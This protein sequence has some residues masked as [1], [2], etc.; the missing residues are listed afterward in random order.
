[1]EFVAKT[2]G[3]IC[4]W[5]LAYQSGSILRR[6]FSDWAKEIFEMKTHLG[7][8]HVDL[9][10]DGGGALPRL[11]EGY[12][13]VSDLV[14]LMA[15]M[16]EVGFSHDEIADYMGRNFHRVLRDCIG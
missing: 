11:I 7:M 4:T 2:G 9:G 15:A 10:T 16:Q 8:A 3:V 14:R 6:T 13:D 5:P 12:R 1:M